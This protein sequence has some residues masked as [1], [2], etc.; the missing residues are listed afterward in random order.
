M[1][2]AFVPRYEGVWSPA[3][4]A[5]CIHNEEAA[6]RLRT[7]GPTPDDPVHDS[8]YLFEDEMFK[9][10]HL[11]R[12]LNVERW[13]REKVVDSYSGRL[14]RRY[15]QALE[16]LECEEELNATDSRLSAFLKA[17]KFNPLAKPSKPRMIMARSPRYNLE[18]ATFL[19][20]LEHALW[21]KLKSDKENGV[22]PSRQVGKGL[23]GK[24]RADLLGRKMAEVGDTVVFEVDGKAFE[25]HVSAR[26]IAAEHRVYRTAYHGD[27]GLD[28]LL[29]KQKVLKGRTACGIR[30]RREGCRASG[31]FNTGMGNSLIM[32]ATV[33]ATMRLYNRTLG[34]FKWDCLVDGDNALIFIER[35]FAGQIRST[36]AQTVMRVVGQ[37][38]AVERPTDTLER[39]EFGQSRPCK[40]STGEGHRYVMVRNPWKAISGA[41]CSYRHYN[42]QKHGLKLL[43]AVSQ[44]ELA[45]NRGVPVLQAY[46]A[47]AVEL[48]KHIRD[49]T[50]PE[51]FL[52]GHLLA[53][54]KA[55]GEKTSPRLHPKPEPAS[56]YRGD[57]VW[58]NSCEWRHL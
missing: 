48:T 31:D 2:R 47:K 58:T 18:L 11:A 44:A 41:F 35:G 33:R 43:K 56:S 39:V 3:V 19:K 37:E 51:E 7:L 20:P 32:L 9:I 30:Y 12:K 23:N 36:F 21:R 1:Y 17:E 45:L 28:K 6:L 53:T 46:F 8:F 54:P 15:Q 52:E 16:S 25:A 49:L 50:N 22:T 38:L 27:V 5:H 42:E 34:K 40:V 14:R 13:S 4:H 29:S 26:Q 57:S 10:A 55:N 24:Q